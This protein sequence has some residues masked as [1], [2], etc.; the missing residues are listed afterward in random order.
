LARATGFITPEIKAEIKKTNVEHTLLINESGDLELTPWEWVKDALHGDKTATV[1]VF[2]RNGKSCAVCWNNEGVG[3]LEIPN[4]TGEIS[5]VE[6]LGGPEIPIE[7]D[8]DSLIIP[9]DK[10][11]YLITD[12]SI[13]KLKNAFI[14]SKLV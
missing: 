2:E 4:I 7:Y 11:R 3:M 5:Y 6:Q 13:D 8:G 14:N 1:F 10:K 9:V 12:L